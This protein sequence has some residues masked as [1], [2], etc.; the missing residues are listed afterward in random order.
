M[1]LFSVYDHVFELVLEKSITGLCRK[2]PNHIAFGKQ[3]FIMETADQTMLLLDIN[4]AN[5][6]GT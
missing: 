2:D 5:A 4:F 1:F 3:L 6:H